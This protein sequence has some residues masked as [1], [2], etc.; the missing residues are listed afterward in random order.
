MRAVERA[1]FDHQVNHNLIISV[2]LKFSFAYKLDMCEN[3]ISF[4]LVILSICVREVGNHLIIMCIARIKFFPS[5][6][7]YEWVRVCTQTCQLADMNIV[8]WCGYW[9]CTV[10]MVHTFHSQPITF[11]LS[12]KIYTITCMTWYV[13]GTKLYWLFVHGIRVQIFSSYTKYELPFV[14]EFR[15]QRSWACLSNTRWKERDCR[16]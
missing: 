12:I 10:Y 2:T 4:L 9:R 14:F 13:N 11:I 5:I 6:L 7:T 8:D 3:K 15:W 1:E 16:R